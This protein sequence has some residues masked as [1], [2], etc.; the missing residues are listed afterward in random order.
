ME[1][2]D[3]VEGSVTEWGKGWELALAYSGVPASALGLVK[4]T[5]WEPSWERHVPMKPPEKPWRQGVKSL[6]GVIMK[7]RFCDGG[8]SYT[9]LHGIRAFFGQTVFLIIL[10]SASGFQ[11]TRSTFLLVWK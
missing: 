11:M 6:S 8:C 2:E 3:C 4:A 1:S 7:N 10:L 9:L 5:A